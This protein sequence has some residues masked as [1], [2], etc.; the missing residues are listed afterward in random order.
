MPN[1][2]AHHQEVVVADPGNAVVSRS[3]MN[4]AVFTDHVVGAN[5]NAALCPRIKSEILGRRA[6]HRPVTDHVAGSDCDASFENGMSLNA[7]A[8][9]QPNVRAD[10][11]VRPD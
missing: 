1:V 6:D 11:A 5:L 8:I 7:T 2:R 10:D 3:A 4:R 9:F